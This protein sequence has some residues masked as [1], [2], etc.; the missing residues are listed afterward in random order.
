MKKKALQIIGGLLGAAVIGAGLYY[1]VPPTITKPVAC[2]FSQQYCDNTPKG[3][4]P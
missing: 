4:Q 3:V 2:T 1:G